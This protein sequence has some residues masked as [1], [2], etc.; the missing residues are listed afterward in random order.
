MDYFKTLQTSDSLRLKDR[1]QVMMLA[2]VDPLVNGSRGIICG[3]VEYTYEDLCAAAAFSSADISSA[4]KY[5]EHNHFHKPGEKCK[6]T[7]P[8]VRFFSLR[9]SKN[10]AKAKIPPYTVFPHRW[11]QITTLPNGNEQVLE[12]IQIPLALAWAATVHKAQGMTLDLAAV[13]IER[14][15]APGQAYVGLSRC[16]STEG[17]QI[18]GWGGK[19]A[20]KRAIKCCEIVR[21]FDAVL[22]KKC[23]WNATTSQSEIPEYDDE[24]DIKQEEEGHDIKQEEDQGIKQ[25]VPDI[26][27][28]DYD[29]KQEETYDTAWAEEHDIKQEKE[30]GHDIVEPAP[31]RQKVDEHGI[32]QEDEHGIKWEGMPDIKQEEEE[33]DIKQEEEHVTKGEEEE[34]YITEEMYDIKEGE[35]YE[36]EQDDE[37]WQ[38]VAL[39]SS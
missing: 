8:Q 4:E 17:L 19:E 14:S 27:Q 3:F 16:R 12:R 7:L 22:Q 6:L 33:H 28:E 38:T 5:F 39:E 23:G 11:Q 20:L 29:I 10:D 25:E 37:W 2:N 21:R 24:H 30:E 13:D 1:A 15:F 32:K 35:I 9:L 26:K 18:L 31:K 34:R 36:F